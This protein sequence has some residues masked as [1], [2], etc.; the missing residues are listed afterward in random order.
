[1]LT[2]ERG[3]FFGIIIGDDEVIGRRPHVIPPPAAASFSI[4]KMK[5]KLN[6]RKFKT[7]KIKMNFFFT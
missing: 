5:I 7:E 3:G 2:F 4:C 6:D 1:M